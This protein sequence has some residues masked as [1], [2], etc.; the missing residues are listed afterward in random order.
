[1]AINKSTPLSIEDVK[2]AFMYDKSNGTLVKRVTA[3]TEYRML[4]INGKKYLEH[5]LIWLLF[6]GKLP[7]LY[8]DHIN[9]DPTD[10]RIENLR[11]VSHKV[12][13]QNRRSPQINNT[14]G[15]LGVSR[16]K[17]GKYDARIQSDGK[18]LYI[19]CFL[20]AQEA[21]NAYLMAKRDLH[22]GCTI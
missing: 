1:M 11:E 22:D 15:Y 5:H 2:E 16:R 20:T 18:N 10:N 7:E 8:I 17:N 3:P 9:G 13:M 6:N 4:S 12:N 19:G 21:H 14:S